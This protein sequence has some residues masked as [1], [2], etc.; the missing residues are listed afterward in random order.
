MVF[1]GTL[2]SLTFGF[3][4]SA[5]EISDRQRFLDATIGSFE[6]EDL[7][8]RHAWFILALSYLYLLLCFLLQVFFFILYNEKFHPFKDILVTEG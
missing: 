5:I 4:F 7:A 3:I 6:E 1:V 8:N 2:M